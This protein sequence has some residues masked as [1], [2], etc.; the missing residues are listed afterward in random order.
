MITHL[1]T[2]KKDIIEIIVTCSLFSLMLVLLSFFM[3]VLYASAISILVSGHFGD[4][5]TDFIF[6]KIKK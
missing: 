5:I 2:V 1:K 3:P 6:N 4:D